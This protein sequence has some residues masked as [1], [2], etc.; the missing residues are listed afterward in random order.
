MNMSLKQKALLN[1]AS[2]MASALLCS[3]AVSLMFTYFSVTTIFTIIGAA[4]FGY[5]CYILYAINLSQLESQERLKE[6]TEKK[7]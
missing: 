6:M 1:T 7:A 4:V 2:L 3:L 5:L